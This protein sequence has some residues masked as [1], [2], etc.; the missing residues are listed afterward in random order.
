MQIEIGELGGTAWV[1]RDADRQ[2][3]RWLIPKPTLSI[4]PR[5]GDGKFAKRS[6]EDLLGRSF[7]L[8]ATCVAF[9]SYEWSGECAKPELELLQLHALQVISEVKRMPG[10][11]YMKLDGK[12]RASVSEV[13]REVIAAITSKLDR[14]V[15]RE[16]YE[17]LLLLSAGC[18]KKGILDEGLK[19]R[20]L[21]AVDRLAPCGAA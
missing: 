20:L 9:S 21:E 16:T 13:H 8:P 3:P 15:G 7:E 17:P 14:C 12:Q 18:A 11:S 1:G 10:M 5:S 2:D 19:S 4:P 6:D